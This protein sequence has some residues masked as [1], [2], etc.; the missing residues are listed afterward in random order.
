MTSKRPADNNEES[1]EKRQRVDGGLNMDS[2]FQTTSGPALI[3]SNV[4]RVAEEVIFDKGSAVGQ[5]SMRARHLDNVQHLRTAARRFSGK[6]FPSSSTLLGLGK[7][8]PRLR[9]NHDG[10]S[11]ALTSYSSSI[12]LMNM[13]SVRRM[14]LCS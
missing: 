13:V 3:E 11:L 4:S 6:P 2:N 12:T 10:S 1:E 14:T 9:P 8:F 7:S 5:L